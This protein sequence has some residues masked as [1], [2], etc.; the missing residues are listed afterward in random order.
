MA[1]PATDPMAPSRNDCAS[2]LPVTC[3]GVAPIARSSASW[4]RWATRIVK[5]FAMVIMP[6]SSAMAAKPLQ[7]YLNTSSP[8]RRL[9]QRLGPGIG[10][11]RDRGIG[12]T[13]QLGL[14]RVGDLLRVCAGVHPHRQLIGAV[15][16]AIGVGRDVADDREQ[17]HRVVGGRTSRIGWSIPSISTVSPIAAPSSRAAASDSASSSSD[18][19]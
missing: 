1:M 11:R 7:R 2:S 6:T 17:R 9:G 16:A 8:G 15:H 4:R 14:Q 19:G 5:V 10:P 13:L 18:A 12:D 3:P